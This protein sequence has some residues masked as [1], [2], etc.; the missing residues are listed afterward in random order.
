MSSWLLKKILIS[1]STRWF[2]LLILVILL[3]ALYGFPAFS[4]IPTAADD[5]VELME[6]SVKTIS[7]LDNDLGV[8]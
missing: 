5:S 1:G 8:A 4:L 7:V 2:L 3:P 6:D